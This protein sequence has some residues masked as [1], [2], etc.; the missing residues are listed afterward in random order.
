MEHYYKMIV[1]YI[2]L[3]S[4]KYVT[5]KRKKKKKKKLVDT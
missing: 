2:G 4:E 3:K 1:K 5:V